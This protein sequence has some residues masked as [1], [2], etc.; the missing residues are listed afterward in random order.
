MH[1]FLFLHTVMQSPLL[2]DPHLQFPPHYNR[3]MIGRNNNTFYPCD[4]RYGYY[5]KG[6]QKGLPDTWNNSRSKIPS[7]IS[8]VC[9]DY[10]WPII[11]NK[12]ATG[13]CSKLIRPVVVYVGG[14]DYFAA[15]SMRKI[16]DCHYVFKL[17]ALSPL[18]RHSKLVPY[19]I[20]PGKINKMWEQFYV[21]KDK[22]PSRGK[23][24][25]KALASFNIKKSKWDSDTWATR[26]L[27]SKL[28]GSV[29]NNFVNIGWAKKEVSFQHFFSEYQFVICPRGKGID[30]Y[31]TWQ[32]L[33]VGS[34]PI[35]ESS[36]INDLY[37]D[38]PIVVV[39]KWEN[40][41]EKM[42]T[43][44]LK[45]IEENWDTMRWEK[46]TNT[47]WRGV[48]KKAVQRVKNYTNG[49]E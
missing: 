27:V 34:I 47:Y 11:L 2:L 46:V 43:R 36:A 41:S 3:D 8:F 21:D 19:P 7:N 32:A 31:R 39:D 25:P 38:L 48:I 13:L 28:S 10:Y 29:W 24:I 12:F 4:L 17:F 49:R 45:K 30:T 42:L 23:K 18:L 22:G 35:V 16:L 40:L 26:N 9:L 14:Y 6:G 20:G 37:K 44:H 5:G 1:V 15:D 33:H